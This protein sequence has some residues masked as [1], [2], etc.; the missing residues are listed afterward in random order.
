MDRKLSEELDEEFPYCLE[1]FHQ[2]QKIKKGA[3]KMRAGDYCIVSLF[4]VSF[5]GL[6]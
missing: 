2:P 3:A 5:C 1:R 6:S 4:S